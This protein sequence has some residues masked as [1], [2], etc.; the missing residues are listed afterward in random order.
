MVGRPTSPNRDDGHTLE[1]TRLCTDGTK[2][3]AS[4]LLAACWKETQE[5]GFHRLGTYILKSENG[6]SLKAAGWRMVYETP[7]GSW[8]KPSRPRRD[9]HPTEPKQ[10]WQPPIKPF[11]GIVTLMGEAD[12]P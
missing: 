5:R 9:K 3:A 10:L 7:G 2:N 12:W 4:M 8:N 1:L 11:V 6:T